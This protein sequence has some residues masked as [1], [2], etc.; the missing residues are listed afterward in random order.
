MNTRSNKNIYYKLITYA[1]I[2]T[3]IFPIFSGL[4]F[5]VPAH[6]SDGTTNSLWSLL[7]GLF[8]LLGFSFLSDRV[9][10]DTIEENY[11]S[12]EQKEDT[13][14]SGSQRLYPSQSEIN[15]FAKIVHAEARGEPFMGQVGV[16]AVVINRVLDPNF[17]NTLT[18]V[19]Y[20]KHGGKYAFSAV[21]DGQI[22]LEPD[23]NAYEA[24]D[25]ALNGFD[26]SR[27][28]LYYY[29]P[30]TATDGWIFENTSEIRT[31]GNHVFAELKKS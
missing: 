11:K 16:A 1:L 28:S 26:P 4:I 2:F 12:A 22:H 6:A 17:P 25:Y 27:G 5:I 23:D 18:D 31:I 15:D 13:N 8:M 9:S 20:Q 14:S 24:I 10:D 7:K 30:V 21:W 19:I 29:N 3:L